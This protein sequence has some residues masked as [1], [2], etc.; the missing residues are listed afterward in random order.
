MRPAVLLA[1]GLLGGCSSIGAISGTVAGVAT[2]AGTANPVVGY[3]VGVGTQAA[4]D[5]LVKYV[6]RKRQQ[7]EQDQIA[8]T[9][10]QLAPGQT[11]PWKIEHDI[12]FGN[13]HGDVTV[14]RVIDNNLARCKEVVHGDRRR[15]ARRT[16]RHLRHHGLRGRSDLEMGAGGPGD[17]AVGIAA[18]ANGF[19]G[20]PRASDIK[21]RP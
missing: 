1:A 2:G 20:R 8:Q 19:S 4:V 13:E 14:A 11:A 12:P 10:G 6:G 17:R 5:S 7:G 16:A 9:V 15:Q 3:A 21:S 18:V